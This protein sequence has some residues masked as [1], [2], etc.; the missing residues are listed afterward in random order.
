[1][2]EPLTPHGDHVPDAVLDELKL[3]F[4]LGDTAPPT[5]SSPRDPFAD[6]DVTVLPDAVVDDDAIALAL[7]AAG[8]ADAPP[9]YADVSSGAGTATGSPSAPLFESDTVRVLPVTPV[10]PIDPVLGAVAAA[11]PSPAPSAPAARLAGGVAPEGARS[12]STIVIG[13]DDDLPDAVYLDEAEPIVTRTGPDD[14]AARNTIVIGDELDSSGAFDAVAVPARSMDPRVRARRIAVKRAAGRKRLVWTVVVVG[15]VLVVVAVLAVFSSSL[16]AVEQVDVQGATYTAARNDA[17]LQAVID[18]LRGEPVLLVDT[19]QAEI[20]LE[21]IPWIERAF[22]STDFPN[23][24]LIDVRERL[25]L[26]TYAG[27]DDRYRVIDRDGRVLDVLDGRPADYM[28]LTGT[29]PDLEPG[30]L[31]GAPFAQAAQLVGALP[32]ELRARTLSASVD[33]TTGDLGLVLQG[34]ADPAAPDVAPPDIEVR[35]GNA[36][37]LD[38]KLARLLQQIR[39][40]LDGVARLDVSTDEVIRSPI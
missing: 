10:A 9:A 29:G 25:P 13:G 22:V 27:S 26:A 30:A 21:Q 20:E 34:D 3:A 24:V 35:L 33:A 38:S 18:E 40:G 36:S 12:R 1:V 31:A 2:S 37:G 8:D 32:A 17:E 6:P 23:R 19:R 28:L 16:F 5:G 7:A 4:G 15:V 14:S 39:D 11:A